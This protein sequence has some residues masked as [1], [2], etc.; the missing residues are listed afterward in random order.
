MVAAA[1]AVLVPVALVASLAVVQA[2]RVGAVV[3]HTL[4]VATASQKVAVAS[5]TLVAPPLPYNAQWAGGG[6]PEALV[7]V[8]G[9]LP[10]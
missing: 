10:P 4:L 9:Y 6:S 7:P 5:H 1:V 8:H 3:S 2:A